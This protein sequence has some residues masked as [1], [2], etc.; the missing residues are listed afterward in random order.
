MTEHQPQIYTCQKEIPF[1]GGRV[2]FLNSPQ[3]VHSTM[4][5]VEIDDFTLLIDCGANPF[6]TPLELPDEA[7]E[8]DAVFLTHGHI[9]HVGGIP[10]LL[11]SGYFAPIFATETTLAITRITLGDYIRQKGGEHRDVR[12][13]TGGF[14]HIT[15]SVSFDTSFKPFAKRDMEVTFH[16]SGH[17]LGAAAIEIKTDKSR[18]LFSGDIGPKGAHVAGP[19]KTNWEP[20]TTFDLVVME[21]TC[22]NISKMQSETEVENQLR[23]IIANAQNK[24][25]HII[26]P[27]SVIGRAQELLHHITTLAK[28]DSAFEVPIALDSANGLRI[29]NDLKPLEQ[30]LD[31]EKIH[32]LSRSDDPL[33]IDGLYTV[34]KTK[35]PKK[36]KELSKTTL[37]ITGFG[38]CESGRVLPQLKELL[39]FDETTLLFIGHQAP[40]TLGYQILRTAQKTEDGPSETIEIQQR[41]IPLRATVETIPGLYAHAGQQELKSWLEAIPSVKKV[42][43]HHGSE[44][45][46]LALATALTK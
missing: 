30:L 10:T 35:D 11:S 1:N 38:N 39:P 24:G 2:R 44:E 29:A 37:I 43:L 20:D 6:E 45:A 41:E 40:G 23:A 21:S 3:S 28:K 7:Y 25:G 18:I 17:I 16:R 14:D 31:E 26:V 9:D 32:K 8:A 19:P 46:Q 4:S 5:L 13:F 22:G 33:N 15:R 12:A 42:A 36:L 27:A 34:R